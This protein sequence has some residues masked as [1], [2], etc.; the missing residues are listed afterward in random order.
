[1]RKKQKNHK[2]SVFL[3]FCM[4]CMV[5]CTTM[6]SL[7][8]A[9]ASGY[10]RNAALQYAEENWDVDGFSVQCAEF[11]SNALSAGGRSEWSRSAS[12]LLGQLQRSGAGELVELPFSNGYVNGSAYGDKLIG[13]PV[14]FYCSGCTDGK[15]Y[16]HVVL[17]RSLDDDGDIRAYSHNAPN[18]GSS[19]YRYTT[20]CYACGGRISKAYAYV[21]DG[22][23]NVFGAYDG[24][25]TENNQVLVTGWAIDESN[26][27]DAVEVVVNIGGVEE[28][29][30]M[31]DWHRPDVEDAYHLGD[32]H[33]FSQRIT[34]GIRGNQTVSVYAVGENQTVLLG[35]KQV[36]IQ[37]PLRIDF[38]FT[39][40][41]MNSDSDISYS[42]NFGGDGIAQMVAYSDN[43]EAAVVTLEDVNWNDCT[44]KIHIITKN[45]ANGS[46]NIIIELQDGNGGCLQQKTIPVTVKSANGTSNGEGEIRISTDH[47]VMDINTSDEFVLE[48]DPSLGAAQILPDYPSAD[49]CEITLSE[50]TPSMARFQVQGRQAGVYMARY[51]LI[52]V[53][54]NEVGKTQIEIEI[55][56]SNTAQ[57]YEA[58]NSRMESTDV[59]EQTTSQVQENQSEWS[60]DWRDYLRSAYDFGVSC[61]R[62]AR[63]YIESR[64]GW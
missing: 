42:F 60:R 1:M 11:V 59:P 24:A 15:P 31:A 18:S 16:V 26:P 51:T 33:G 36:N 41:E 46:F 57:S 8:V 7:T 4:V 10:D 37:N 58:E 64:W 12:D 23:D 2:V 38:P 63:T 28:Y 52:D 17:C 29:R 54:G 61:G 48:W 14:W 43:S 6:F 5:F 9:A 22:Q 21:F 39:N 40:L 44:G 49:C 34:T 25:W 27:T 35:E 13:C 62:E 50:I 30:F 32:H 20:T 19:T 56:D 3:A 53:N 45:N 47:M 55:Q